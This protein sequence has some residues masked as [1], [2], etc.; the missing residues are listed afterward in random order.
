MNPENVQSEIG[1]S[2]RT[3]IVWLHLWAVP[4]I[5][6]FMETENK[7]V[8]VTDSMKGKIKNYN[9]IKSEYGISIWEYEVLEMMVA[10]GNSVNVLNAT[11]LYT[12]KY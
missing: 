12:L 6:K 10:T 11:V 5:P 7:M 2:Q 3:N 9:L 4:R 1:Q 8:V